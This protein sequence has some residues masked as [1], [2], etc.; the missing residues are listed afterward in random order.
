SLWML[1]GLYGSEHLEMGL[2]YSRLLKANRLFVQDIS[3]QNHELTPGPKLYVF[4]NPPKLD[5]DN[6]WSLVHDVTIPGF[7]HKEWAFWLNRKSK[8][9]LDYNLQS[10]SNLFLVIA[11]GKSNYNEWIQDTGN[12]DWC[13]LWKPV[14]GHGQITFET[15]KDDE[16]YIGIANLH[17]MSMQ[18]VLKMDI[19][20]KVYETDE[21]DFWC[22]L[23]VKPCRVALPLKGS[24]VGVVTTPDKAQEGLDVWH[25]TVSYNTRWAT[26]IVIYGA[27]GLIMLSIYS[28]RGN[29]K[30][31]S[32]IFPEVAPLNSQTAATYD[33]GNPAVGSV[34]SQ[35]E[36]K[37]H[38]QHAH[39]S[40]IDS[41]AVEI[42][43][44][45]LCTICFEERKDSF[46]QP[47]GHCATCHSCGL[48]FNKT[49]NRLP[50]ILRPSDVSCLI[51]YSDAFDKKDAYYLRDKNPTTLRQAFTM[52]LQIENNIKE[53]GK[54][55]KREGIKLINPEKPQ[56]SKSMD[57]EEVVK[58]LARAVKEISYK[59]ARVEKGIGQG[60]QGHHKATR[61]ATVEEANEIEWCDRCFF[62]HAPCD[63]EKEVEEVDDDTDDDVCMVGC[64]TSSQ[65]GV[66]LIELISAKT[67]AYFWDYIHRVLPL[68]PSH[69]FE[70]DM[71][72]DFEF[73]SNDF[74]YLRAL[75]IKKY[76][77]GIPSEEDRQLLMN[78][79]VGHEKEYNTRSKVV[80]GAGPQAKPK[81]PV[82]TNISKETP[83]K[84]TSGKSLVSPNR[85]GI[86]VHA[87]TM[88]NPLLSYEFLSLPQNVTLPKY[89]P[90]DIAQVLS[91]IKIFVPIVEL[92]RIPEHKKRAFEYLD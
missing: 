49:L 36:W 23:D 62:P 84:D 25:V 46:F 58:T 16:Y 89:V 18:L 73:P 85:T 15:T 80:K 71:V 45:N 3:V 76:D 75:M 9:K 48:R 83:K 68:P 14:H 30:K 34:C 69:T 17:E 5:D 50:V 82:L 44:E 42:P 63:E 77:G 29:S 24:E 78:V 28:C 90:Y 59:L 87:Q 6:E 38:C 10:A 70:I 67:A 1:L 91:Q 37:P 74:E 40:T 21:A 2:N 79:V 41:A 7:Y 60:S 57:L 52:A 11:Q 47:C 61:V 22:P 56:S 51:K 8:V 43:D 39:S 64:S 65:Q 33:G 13:L 32:E 54:P 88:K 72:Q 53:I 12:P 55:P 27:L 86:P 66:T 26:Y 35:D 19:K 92:L 20:A 4:R 81:T 31:R